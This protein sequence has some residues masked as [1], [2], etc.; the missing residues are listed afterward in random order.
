VGV[1]EV[2][3]TSGLRR[4]LVVSEAALATA[5]LLG[6]ALTIEALLK[7]NEVDL[8]FRLDNLLVMR[9]E[10]PTARYGEPERRIALR[11]LLL[12]RVGTVPGIVSVAEASANPI[13]GSGGSHFLDVAGREPPSPGERRTVEFH[14]VSPGYFQTMEWPLRRGRHFDERDSEGAPPVASVTDTLVRQFFPG[15]D[16]LGQLVTLMPGTGGQ[17]AQAP[18]V[19]RQIVGV[20]G[21]VKSYAP[22]DITV[23]TI[24]VPYRQFP[25][26]RMD[27]VVRTQA[28]PMSMLR[29]VQATLHDVEPERHLQSAPW[30]RAMR[31]ESPRVAP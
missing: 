1:S 18:Q 20:I 23:P 11:R 6:A 24:F 3:G 27:L 21:D 7:L 30:S 12:E 14:A 29:V 10:P 2:P 13:S 16:P 31:R 26:W 4:W 25:V 19:A 28:D 22:A 5:L 15:Q 8:G 9:T 17:A